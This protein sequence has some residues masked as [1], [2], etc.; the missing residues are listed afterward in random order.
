MPCGDGVRAPL[1]WQQPASSGTSEASS[2]RGHADGFVELIDEATPARSSP[3]SV[4]AG[5]GGGPKEGSP[6][7]NLHLDQLEEVAIKAA[8]AGAKTPA[9]SRRASASSRA[10]YL[11]NPPKSAVFKPADCAIL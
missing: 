1:P 4:I 2:A 3:A 7:K 8:A 5:A 11:L 9:L 10:N 6:I